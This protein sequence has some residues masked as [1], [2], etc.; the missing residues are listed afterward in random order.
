M[1]VSR[2]RRHAFT[3]IVNPIPGG[4]S[5]DAAPLPQVALDQGQRLGEGIVLIYCVRPM[6]GLRHSSRRTAIVLNSGAGAVSE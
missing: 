1:P 6:F 2:R 4:A 5:S 3:I